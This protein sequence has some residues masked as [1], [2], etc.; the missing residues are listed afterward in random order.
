MR[1]AVVWG[2]PPETVPPGWEIHCLS[3]GL[4][5]TQVVAA[6][7]AQPTAV[8]V[9]SDQVSAPSVRTVRQQLPDLPFLLGPG[10]RG[11]HADGL[12]PACVGP[13]DAE[14][15]D[16]ADARRR[17]TAA[18][19]VT[20]FFSPRGGCGTTTVLAAVALQFGRWREEAVLVD[21]N[22]HHPDLADLFAADG[23]VPP[24]E[25]FF[26]TDRAPVRTVAASGLRLVPG[27]GEVEAAELA[28]VEAVDQLLLRLRGPRLLVDTS[29][30][31]GDPATYAALRRATTTV[32]V[33]DA[34]RSSRIHVQRYRRTMLQLGLG[35]SEALLV[36]NRYPRA[37]PLS[38]EEIASEV[39]LDLVA[40]LPEIPELERRGIDSAAGRR[41]ASAV[42]RLAAVVAGRPFPEGRYRVGRR[43]GRAE[44]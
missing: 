21:L 10:V 2:D 33:V 39:G 44:R 27:L 36:L 29:S 8:L 3:A 26:G 32:L 15:L 11:A 4:T 18:L 14:H 22:L 40:V 1:L 35:W 30:V 31:L 42:E 7:S 6:V 25:S 5:A 9:I 20:V 16:M 41:L 13:L 43:V 12:A 24:L 19:P 17:G 23:P 37:H 28:T 34:R 38:P